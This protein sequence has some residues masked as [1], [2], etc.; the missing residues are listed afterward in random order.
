M[1][2]REAGEVGVL[3]L[4]AI[5]DPDFAMSQ[6]RLAKVGALSEDPDSLLNHNGWDR[7]FMI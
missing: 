2:L 5:P 7:D 6:S 4:L 3:G 1:S